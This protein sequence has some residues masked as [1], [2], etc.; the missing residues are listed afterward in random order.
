MAAAVSRLGPRVVIRL[1]S[2]GPIDRAL[3][4]ARRPHDLGNKLPFV[5]CGAAGP[6]ILSD[7][8]SPPSKVRGH[9]T[10]R[11]LPFGLRQL[12]FGPRPQRPTTG[13]EQV[14]ITTVQGEISKERSMMTMRQP[15]HSFP[16]SCALVSALVTL[17]LWSW[18]PA[19]AQEA[20]DLDILRE[21]ALVLVNQ[22]R[23]REGM[24]ELAAGEN[25]DEAALAH[26]EDMAHRDYYAH[27][28]P[29][30]DTARD[31]FID[32]GGSEWELVAENI[33]RCVGCPLPPDVARV[34]ELQQGWMNSPEHRANI[35]HDGLSRFGFGIAAGQD[36]KLYAVQTFGGPGVPLGGEDPDNDETIAPNEAVD[37]ALSEVNAARRE[38]NLPEL[39]SSEALSAS[40]GTLVPD[41]LSGFS[42]DALGDA[43]EAL[44]DDERLGWASIASIAGTCGGCGTE[45]ARS[46]VRSFA[47]DWLDEGSYRESFLNPQATHMGLV[48]RAD[49]TGRKVAL[50]LVGQQR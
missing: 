40:A 15:S 2:I 50:A 4:G 13:W 14:V 25:L 23:S 32:A 38:A 47:S 10:A 48:L 7:L 26:A 9:G 19:A 41:D 5:G 27:E 30:G 35:L 39:A 11:Q 6:P 46:D 22:A 33:A 43:F 3:E 37:L 24:S 34:E 44:P 20:G 45:A 28:S 16:A 12:R 8:P 42:L 1:A 31:R 17:A 36:G 29:E 49:G 18:A 21:S